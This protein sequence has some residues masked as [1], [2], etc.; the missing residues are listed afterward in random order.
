MRK[1]FLA[2]LIDKSY[3]DE[4]SGNSLGETIK[5]QNCKPS[6]S[7]KRSDLECSHPRSGHYDKKP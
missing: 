1:V 6:F 2:I 4:S 7:P 5:R 3:T